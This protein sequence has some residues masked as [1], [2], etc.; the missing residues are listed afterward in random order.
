MIF[1]LLPV[2]A[3]VNAKQRLNKLLTPERREALARLMY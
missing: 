3:P 2:K 1:G